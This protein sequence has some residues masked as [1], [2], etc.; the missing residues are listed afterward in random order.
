M[1]RI[2]LSLALAAVVLLAAPSA[3]ASLRV[4]ACEPEWGALATAIG[5]GDV[6]VYTATTGLQDPHQI[7]AR[8]ALIS[9]LRNADI[10][11]CTGA[12]LEIGWLPAL[13]QES[14]NANIQPGSPGY[15]E[16]AS[17]VRLL[18]VPSAVDRAI[19]SSAKPCRPKARTSRSR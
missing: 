19:T 3:F 1:L 16:A 17:A 2:R 13:L 4:F 11:V 14:G 12:E 18:D 8:P 9:R 7:Q 5:G 6:D 10:A 15:F